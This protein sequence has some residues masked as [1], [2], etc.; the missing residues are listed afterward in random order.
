MY[1]LMTAIVIAVAVFVILK[2]TEPHIII[3]KINREYHEVIGKD[4][5]PINQKDLE[6]YIS[7]IQREEAKASP[8]DVTDV[9]KQLLSEFNGGE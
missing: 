7:E 5:E 6:T 2:Y 4:G 3:E 1:S 8:S 9:V